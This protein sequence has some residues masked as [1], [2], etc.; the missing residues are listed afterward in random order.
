MKTSL[1]Q[2]AATLAKVSYMQAS[3]K[4]TA[5]EMSSQMGAMRAAVA[6]SEQRNAS[7]VESAKKDR[8]ALETLISSLRVREAAA[9]NAATLAQAEVVRLS[10]ATEQKSTLGS[11]VAGGA[12]DSRVQ[13]E[14]LESAGA[15]RAT[16]E[17]SLQASNTNVTRLQSQVQ[18][19]VASEKG[20]R[21]TVDATK[22]DASVLAKALKS[23]QFQ[24]GI[25]DRA[26]AERLR[27]LDAMRALVAS[28][29]RSKGTV[30]AVLDTEQASTLQ[31]RKDNGALVALIT[32]LRRAND[33]QT[34]AMA[35]TQQATVGL[36]GSARVAPAHPMNGDGVLLA[37][38][39]RALES[40]QVTDVDVRDGGEDGGVLVQLPPRLA[41]GSASAGVASAEARFL[42]KLGQALGGLPKTSLVVEGHTDNVPLSAKTRERFGSNLE[43]SAA[44]AAQA[45][46]HI[47]RA[48]GV[49]AARVSAR[50]FGDVRP[51]SDNTTAQGRRLNRRVELRVSVL[52]E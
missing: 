1:K 28:Y 29:E 27:D 5:D 6:Q 19:L 10:A 44:R 39:Q 48:R 42:A 25:A 12:A 36:G 8:L 43:I 33:V 52:H 20:L 16:L 21:A 47:A 32:S 24:K 51:V 49:D 23:N 35:K 7:V 9:V 40:T 34:Q 31:L 3:E 15:Q 11:S 41:F 45:A 50:G 17:A 46:A 22:K 37:Q 30:Q 18:T 2:Q 14:K 38:V 26:L 13:Q 4:V